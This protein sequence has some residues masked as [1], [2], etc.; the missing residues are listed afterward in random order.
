MAQRT[1]DL[2]VS[3]QQLWSLLWRRFDP[4]PRTFH[5]LQVRSY[6]NE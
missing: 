2:V 6:V 1:K 5:M 3:L 4:W